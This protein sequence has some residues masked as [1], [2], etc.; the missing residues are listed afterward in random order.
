MRLS[1]MQRSNAYIH[2]FQAFS[3]SDVRKLRCDMLPRLCSLER[4]MLG[5]HF[6][7]RQIVE[8]LYPIYT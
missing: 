3:M 4:L 6:I 2:M 5:N 7:F 1:C 8:Q